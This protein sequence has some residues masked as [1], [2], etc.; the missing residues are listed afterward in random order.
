M[1]D[2]RDDDRR[3]AA[4][5]EAE[6][7]ASW[8]ALQLYQPRGRPVTLG[9][10]Y[11]HRAE[12]TEQIVHAVLAEVWVSEAELEFGRRWKRNFVVILF[13]WVLMMM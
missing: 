1:I 13:S 7:F 8:T 2:G 4:D 12:R 9:R 10:K 3:V 11:G 5:A 6:S